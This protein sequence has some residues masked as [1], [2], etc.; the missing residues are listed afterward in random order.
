MWQGL[1]FFF[2]FYWKGKCQVISNTLSLVLKARGNIS[3]TR[4][5]FVFFHDSED[6]GG[7]PLPSHQ[8]KVPI[9]KHYKEISS[10]TQSTL[11]REFLNQNLWF[12]C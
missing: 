7:F 2:N 9:R 11:I 12:D 8:W 4:N 3:K 6:G 5:F 1:P 10:F